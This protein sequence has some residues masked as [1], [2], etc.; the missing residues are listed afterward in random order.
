LSASLAV[1]SFTVTL[2]R[3]ASVAPVLTVSKPP[4]VTAVPLL[5]TVK[6]DGK[7]ITFDLA[8]NLEVK[9]AKVSDTLT[10]GGNTPTGGTTATP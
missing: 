5:P 6:R 10:I 2:P 1:A 3:S 7:N 4:L 8:K 9:T